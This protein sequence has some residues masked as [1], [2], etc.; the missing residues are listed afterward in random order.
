MEV[1]LSACVLH[2]SMFVVIDS[3]VVI[4]SVILKALL[5]AMLRPTV[6]NTVKLKDLREI[7]NDACRYS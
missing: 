5:V 6:V 4:D 7:T 2:S 3:D 1:I